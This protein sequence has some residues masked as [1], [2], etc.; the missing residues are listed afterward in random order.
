M[1]RLK[2]YPVFLFFLLSVFTVSGQSSG[3]YW[4]HLNEDSNRLIGK[5]RGEIYYVTAISNQYFF[6]QM[7]WMEGIIELT[8]GDVYDNIMVRYNANDDELVAY[9]NQIRSLYIVDKDIV[10]KFSFKEILKNGDFKEREFIKLHYEALFGGDRFFERLYS[11]DRML[12]AFHYVV[13][14][15]VRPY[16]DKLGA[17]RDTEYN[18]KVNYYMHDSKNGFKKIQPKRR[19]IIKAIPEHKKEIK[20]IIRQNNINLYN[21]Y[22]LIQTFML[23]DNAG[24][25]N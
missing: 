16:I 12:L 21:E 22:S 10:K 3:F 20:K 4:N 23:L 7:E 19:S 8:D 9:N 17:M 5:L 15:K 11:G 14:A 6:L 25:L 2:K 18:L 24:L 13:E 1:K